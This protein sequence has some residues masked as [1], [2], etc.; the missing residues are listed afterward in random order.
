M[1]KRIEEIARIM[2]ELEDKSPHLQ[3]ENLRCWLA[4]FINSELKSKKIKIKD[5][6]K[7][8]GFKK[9]EIKEILLANRDLTCFEMV[10][11][12]FELG[13]K[14]NLGLKKIKTN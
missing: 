14:V 13:Y 10:Q 1:D 7:R 4:Q 9:K 8:L 3:Y 5:F 11:I 6:A 2:I 12:L